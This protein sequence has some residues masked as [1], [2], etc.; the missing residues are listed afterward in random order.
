M[1]DEQLIRR[2]DK[3][4][5]KMEG[6][7]YSTGRS[8][9]SP[10]VAGGD[11]SAIAETLG[12]GFKF[13]VDNVGQLAGKAVD[14]TATVNDATKVVSNMLGKFGSVGGMAGDALEGLAS[15][16]TDSV[17]NW[18][19]FSD[20]GL[21][22]GGSAMALREAV[23]KTGLSFNEYASLMDKIQPSFANFGQGLT[24]GAEMFGEASNKILND[25]ALQRSFNLL[26]MNTKDVNSALATVVRGANIV[27]TN[28]KEQMDALLSSALQLAKEMDMMA[29]LTGVSRKEQEK[30]IETM[31]QDER[32]RAQIIL[33]RKQNPEAVGAIG[34]V[35]KNASALDPATQKLLS[36]AIAGKGIMSSDKIA[37]FQKVYGPEAARQIA[38]IGRNVSS[39]D[40][41]L[42]DK[43]IADTQNLIFMLAKERERGAAFIASGAV[44][45][46]FS[47]E[48]LGDRYEIVSK[49]LQAYMKDKGMDETSA[50]RM[51]MEDAKLLGE[52]KLLEQLTQYN[53]KTKQTEVIGERGDKD[54]RIA[55]TTGVTDANT[56]I[57]RFGVALNE[58]VAQMNTTLTLQKNAAGKFK[59]S[60]F[61]DTNLAGYNKAMGSRV[62]DL[63]NTIKLEISTLGE[64]PEKWTTTIADR[65]ANIIN[66][67]K[68]EVGSKK[69][70]GNWFESGPK[71]ILMGEG[72]KEEAVVPKDDLS[73]FFS[74]MMSSGFV[75]SQ[76]TKASSPNLGGILKNV[77]SKISSAQSA[78]TMAT[79]TDSGTA[80]GQD[81]VLEKL[82]KISTIMERVAH[83][84]ER[85]ERHVSD[86]ASNTKD[87]GGYIG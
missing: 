1:S 18:Q 47:K 74:D 56:E 13:A 35:Q 2:I 50:K 16:V 42:R 40:K 79:A 52:G 21:Q 63:S 46:E 64:F 12:K 17:S 32:V 11:L 36:E 54:P 24:K 3:L 87:I 69:A 51:A 19:Q 75:S 66:G 22:F 48:A 81:P 41:N 86:T 10:K 7:N 68:R 77:A 34:E 5:E 9:S 55:L 29:K 72:N 60:E 33:L 45:N 27:N 57:K 83:H 71:R 53:E 84:A 58:I 70:T 43:A 67:E 4:I 85:T 38:D 73:E 44:S 82:D 30:A 8:T 78:D 28:N 6:N 76:S 80:S 62:K 20:F 37:E 61:V 15:I 65:V 23:H 49:N 26:G 31:Q 25:P 14:N 59:A 39:Q